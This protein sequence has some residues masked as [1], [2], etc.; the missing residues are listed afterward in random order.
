MFA[1]CLAALRLGHD[2]RPA[3]D[4]D[5]ALGFNGVRVFGGHLQ[6]AGQTF[7]SALAL[8][9]QFLADCQARD[10]A[11]EVVALTDTGGYSRADCERHLADVAHVARAAGNAIVEGGNE[12]GP[13]HQTQRG[14]I[15]EICRHSP[16]GV[17]YCPGSVHGA[18]ACEDESLM[19]ATQLRVWREEGKAPYWDE[20]SALHGDYG[21]SHL[22]DRS[23]RF[24][25]ERRMRELEH[26]TR[27]RGVPWFAN[28][29]Q[30][31]GEGAPDPS[32]PYEGRRKEEAGRRFTDPQIAVAQGINARIFEVAR[33]FH[34][35]AG[36]WA[37][38]L[39]PT[40]HGCAEAFVRGATVVPVDGPVVVFK[41]GRWADSPVASA[42]FRDDQHPHGTVLR[43]FSGVHGDWGL[44]L[45]LGVTGDPQ[46][47][48]GAGY[49]PV[50]ELW[51]SANLIVWE[52]RR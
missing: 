16:Q 4:E 39:G 35:Q 18:S 32:S 38:P 34:S 19:T 9:P 15:I 13:P 17:L 43:V 44:T 3:L 14:D 6:W 52:V 21:T 26:S 41:N 37:E 5:V 46:I 50:Q 48:W 49:R 23:D 45:A 2:Y 11:V 7:A 51:H 25:A 29:Q 28:E 1:S 30:G 47:A 8:M 36:L 27:D 12:I 22:Q 42:N 10:L 24:E 40:Q 31:A 33:T 20:I